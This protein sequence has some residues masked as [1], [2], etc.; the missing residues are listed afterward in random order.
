M[1]VILPPQEANSND[2]GMIPMLGT[3]L[4]H[5]LR[6]VLLGSFCGGGVE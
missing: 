3:V 5:L 2:H 1:L 4:L 6:S